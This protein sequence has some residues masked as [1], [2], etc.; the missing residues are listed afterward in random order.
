M[1]TPKLTK[2]HIKQDP[3]DPAFVQNPYAVYDKMHAIEGPVFWENYNMWCLT[4]FALKDKRFAR[5]PPAGHEKTPM[6]EHLS[7]FAQSEKYS[8]LSLEPPEHTRLRKLV[9]RAFISRQVAKMEEG[10]RLHGYCTATGCT[11]V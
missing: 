7:D 4:G 5:L 3:K 11:R 6:A 9:N 8:L 10:I 1:A 2:R